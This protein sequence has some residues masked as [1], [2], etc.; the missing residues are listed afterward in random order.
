ML[1]TKT[2]VFWIIQSKVGSPRFSLIR[3]LSFSLII[4]PNLLWIFLFFFSK[5]TS[6]FTVES[7][8]MK[9]WVLNLRGFQGLL[10]K[11]G[12]SQKC[13]Q[14]RGQS[15]LSSWR[16]SP[17]AREAYSGRGGGSASVSLWSASPF[18]VRSSQAPGVYCWGLWE[19]SQSF[20]SPAVSQWFFQIPCASHLANH[21]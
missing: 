21:T 6:L 16:A 15:S 11:W 2:E 1:F 20:S 5:T 14:P 3:L 17:R 18:T 8:N 19:Y 12:S 10:I 4:C 7:L 9:S 13:S